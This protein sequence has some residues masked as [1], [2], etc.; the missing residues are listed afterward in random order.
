MKNNLWNT[1]KQFFIETGK[2]ISGHTEITG[3]ST[4][5]FKYLTWM[6]TCLLCEKA[7][8]HSNAKACVFSDSVLC[9]GKWETILLQPGRGKFNSIGKRPLQRNESNRWHCDGARAEN[10]PR[11]HNVGPPRADSKA[12]GRFEV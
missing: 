12:N 1:T 3:I 8:H 7:C 5:D 9:L 4:V 11:N 2:L 10:I 6:S